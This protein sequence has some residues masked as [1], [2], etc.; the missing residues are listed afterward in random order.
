MSNQCHVKL[1]IAAMSIVAT[2][3]VFATAAMANTSGPV[4]NSRHAFPTETV[5]SYGLQMSGGT[6]GYATNLLADSSI[7]TSDSA[8]E[9]P[10]CAFGSLLGLNT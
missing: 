7:P 6:V 2:S 9:C 1:L 8:F 10:S 3:S 5:L 4:V